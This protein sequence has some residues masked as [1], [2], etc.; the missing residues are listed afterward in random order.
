[1]AIKT[2]QNLK[3]LITEYL[4]AAQAAQPERLRER[5]MVA[6]A[7]SVTAKLHAILDQKEAGDVPSA[8]EAFLKQNWYNTQHTMLCY[9][10]MPESDMTQMA[11]KVAEFVAQSRH[12]SQPLASA[13]QHPLSVIELLMPGICTESLDDA[14]PDLDTYDVQ[15]LLSHH[16]LGEGSYLIPVQLL[17]ELNATELHADATIQLHNVYFDYEKHD[18]TQ[19]TINEAELA[20]LYQHSSE[21][22]ALKDAYDTYKTRTEA[23]STLLDNLSHLCAKLHLNSANMQGTENDAG[24]GAYPAI[25]EFNEYYDTL[26][27]AEKARIPQAVSA[28]IDKLLDLSSDKEQNKNATENLE[29]CVATRRSELLKAI[30]GKEDTLRNIA[31]TDEHKKQLAEVANKRFEQCQHALKSSITKGSYSG[32]DSLGLTSG[33]LERL[34]IELSVSWL[35]DLHDFLSLTPEEITN[36][37]Q[38]EAFKRQIISQV[39]TI[40]EWIVLATETPVQKL[41]ALMALIGGRLANRFIKDPADVA[42]LLMTLTPE[43]VNVVC[44][45]ING[46]LPEIIK[47]AWG[48]A[49]VLKHLTLEQRTSVY[50]AMK[51]KLPAIIKNGKDFGCAL[52][53]LTIAQRTSVYRAMKDKLPDIIEKYNA[54][55]VIRALCYLTPEQCASVCIAIKDK[56]PDLIQYSSD[57]GQVL[58]D[59]SLEQCTSVCIAMRD[60]LPEM[61]RNGWDYAEVLEPLSPEQRT[62]FCSAIKD[63]LPE[64]IQNV[65]SLKSFLKNTNTE[66]QTHF[67]K[68]GGADTLL[69][70]IITNVKKDI[71]ECHQQL[72]SDEV[73]NAF[74]HAL[75]SGLLQELEVFINNIPGVPDGY[76]DGLAQLRAASDDYFNAYPNNH[77]KLQPFQRTCR[78]HINNIETK[79]RGTD[80]LVPILDKLRLVGPIKSERKLQGRQSR[81]FVAPR[82]QEVDNQ[83][84]DEGPDFPNNNLTRRN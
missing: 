33:L 14:Y 72:K 15:T 48:L 49:P 80:G 18:A 54:Y 39:K 81:F 21:T 1:M 26:A 47:D 5:V 7:R 65:D 25:I 69:A 83:G 56:R 46:K 76:Q 2:V 82:N 66:V 52:Q 59:L 60:K 24:S 13:A 37:G 32:H 68:S 55:D 64:I 67:F 71:S 34:T 84:I 20:R 77:G 16:V 62:S 70:T 8:L 23:K 53:Y 30:E 74:N 4:K 40:D 19:A 75:L 22:H 73:K 45:A 79:L 12:Q 41:E 42:A 38:T 61:I 29:T 31:V 58:K 57:V 78:E 3:N 35:A 17:T 43:R 50:N 9:T 6:H 44:G 10:A 36:I 51:N 28:E 27:E 11:I 63:K